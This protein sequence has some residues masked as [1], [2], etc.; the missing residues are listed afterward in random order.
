VQLQGKVFPK[1]RRKS[2]R[3]LYSSSLSSQSSESSFDAVPADN[4]EEETDYVFH[5]VASTGQNYSLRT[6]WIFFGFD[7]SESKLM[8]EIWR[9][10]RVKNVFARW[11]HSVHSLEGHPSVLLSVSQTCSWDF[12]SLSN[13]DYIGSRWPLYRV[14]SPSFSFIRFSTIHPHDQPTND[15]SYTTRS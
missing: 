10:L 14:A 9:N 12:R 3:I 1:L 7:C 11:Q 15:I 6:Y 8:K 5:I 13:T 2:S 4:D